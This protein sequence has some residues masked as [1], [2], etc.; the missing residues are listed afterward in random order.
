MSTC[1]CF[2]NVAAYVCYMFGQ[3][4]N[5]FATKREHSGHLIEMSSTNC[6]A[7]VRSCPEQALMPIDHCYYPF[8]CEWFWNVAA[9]VCYM[10]GQK[11]HTKQFIAYHYSSLLIITHHYAI[12]Y[13]SLLIITQIVLLII[14][15]HYTTSNGWKF[16]CVVGRFHAT[17]HCILGHY[18]ILRIE[19]KIWVIQCITQ[20][21]AWSN[22][23]IGRIWWTRWRLQWYVQQRA[24]VWQ[25]LPSLAC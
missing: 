15:H 11:P 7:A 22:M 19:Q 2:W 5:M 21:F 12:H 4:P 10:F 18:A 6:K 1:E 23:F 16:Y 20:I 14:T 25:W 24:R 8:L 9:Y 3:K 17:K 13:S